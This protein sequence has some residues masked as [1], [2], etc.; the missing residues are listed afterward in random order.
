M[1]PPCI[2]PIERNSPW[3]VSLF[4]E[5]RCAGPINC[6]ALLVSH[7]NVKIANEHADLFSRAHPAKCKDRNVRITAQTN[8]DLRNA[9]QSSKEIK[10]QSACSFLE[11]CPNKIEVPQ[12][13]HV[14]RDLQTETALISNFR[15]SQA[16]KFPVDNAKALLRETL[17]DANEH[18]DL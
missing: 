17:V 2:H 8:K 6:Q 18:N 10:D 13:S 16:R 4:V 11:V 1:R 9:T 12:L 3:I 5:R 15:F 14:M 7:M